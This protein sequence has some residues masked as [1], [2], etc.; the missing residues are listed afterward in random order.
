M[1]NLRVAAF[2]IRVA[3]T[4]LVWRNFHPN[5]SPRRIA[6]NWRGVLHRQPL[7]FG[8]PGLGVSACLNCPRHRTCCVLLRLVLNV[9]ETWNKS[10]VF[11]FMSKAEKLCCWCVSHGSLTTTNVLVCW[12][13]PQ[14]YQIT[15]DNMPQVL[16]AKHRVSFGYYK[17]DTSSHNSS[18]HIKYCTTT[19]PQDRRGPTLGLRGF[20]MRFFFVPKEAGESRVSYEHNL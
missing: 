12:S 1:A 7:P 2:Y 20:S 17:M 13:E 9:R 4:H 19:S 11:Q 10:W 5:G 8:Y 15:S 3:V 16:P 14:S 18:L 6:L